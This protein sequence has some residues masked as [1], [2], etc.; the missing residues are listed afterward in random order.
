LIRPPDNPPLPPPPTTTIPFLIPLLFLHG[1]HTNTPVFRLP[2]SH[3]HTFTSICLAAYTA[4]QNKPEEYRLH[5]YLRPEGACVEGESVNREVWDGGGYVNDVEGEER[6]GG[7]FGKRRV[8]AHFMRRDVHGDECGRDES[9]V[10]AAQ[11]GASSLVEKRRREI[12]PD[13][14][15][16]YSLCT[17]IP[18]SYYGV[19]N[20]HFSAPWIF[21]PDPDA[22]SRVVSPK[23]HP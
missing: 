2:S 19:K 12:N 14:T 5:L 11:V 15:T 8:W 10:T 9:A 20:R 1:V 7:E 21:I 6:K 22:Q 23:F 4:F 18:A 3:F 16:V 13:S 17:P